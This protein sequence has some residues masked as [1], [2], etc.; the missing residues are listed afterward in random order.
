MMKEWEYEILYTNN[1]NYDIKSI[2]NEKGYNGWE[3]IQVINSPNGTFCCI[4]KREM[5]P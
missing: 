3:L 1:F 5:E 4:F 2:L